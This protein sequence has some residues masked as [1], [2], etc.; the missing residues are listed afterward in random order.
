MGIVH[1][2]AGEQRANG[3]VSVG[4]IQMRLITTP[5]LRMAFTALFHS[6]AAFPRQVRQLP[7]QRLLALAPQPLHFRFD[8][9]FH[10]SNFQSLRPAFQLACQVY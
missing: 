1:A 7:R 10:A 2:G 5:V 6:H 9:V 4:H 3:N 8:A